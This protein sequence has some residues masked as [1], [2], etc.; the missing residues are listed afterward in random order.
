[1]ALF[2]INEV[3]LTT[4][5]KALFQFDVEFNIGE[6]YLSGTAAGDRGSFA[7]NLQGG[8]TMVV[9]PSDLLVGLPYVNKARLHIKT[10]SETIAIDTKLSSGLDMIEIY[11][12]LLLQKM[13][14]IKQVALEIEI[15]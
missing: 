4:M 12:D 6:S 8:S 13:V 10:E 5:M 14:N 1:M 15:K 2:I 11:D 3:L 9:L 7:I